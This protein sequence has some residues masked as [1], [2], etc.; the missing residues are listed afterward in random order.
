[1]TE[2]AFCRGLYRT[3]AAKWQVPKDLAPKDSSSDAATGGLSSPLKTSKDSLT[4]SL[5]V[6]GKLAPVFLAFKLKVRGSY[7]G[8]RHGPHFAVP[9]GMGVGSATKLGA[10]TFALCLVACLVI[11]KQP[12]TYQLLA[13]QLLSPPTSSL[14]YWNCSTLGQ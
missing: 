14:P 11:F 5:S 9:V 2:I 1:M 10:W 7:E 3:S 12:Q 6:P 4:W 8:S 13:Q